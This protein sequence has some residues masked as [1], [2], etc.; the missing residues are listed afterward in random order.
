MKQNIIKTKYMP[1]LT[2]LLCIGALS[3]TG[4]SDEKDQ[5]IIPE[6]STYKI[7]QAVEFEISSNGENLFSILVSPGGKIIGT[8]KLIKPSSSPEE[9]ENFIANSPT[10]GEHF[11]DI[12]DAADFALKLS[13]KPGVKDISIRRVYKNGLP[14]EE[15]VV[16]WRE[17]A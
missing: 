1:I 14:T 9:D 12:M 16:L 15:Y 13:E 2:I 11:S 7:A 5:Y 8:P 10:Y 3:F 6:T 4:C 17:E